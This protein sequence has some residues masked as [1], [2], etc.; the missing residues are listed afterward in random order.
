LS[1]VVTFIF[2]E[3]SRVKILETLPKEVVRFAENPAL[4]ADLAITAIILPPEIFALGY[5]AS[6]E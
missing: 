2:R 4:T 3:R 5:A 1:G 6:P